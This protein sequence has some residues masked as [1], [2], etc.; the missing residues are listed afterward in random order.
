MQL[1]FLPQPTHESPPMF[2]SRFID[3]F[4]RTHW[5][6]VPII[7]GP[8]VLA[9]LWFAV[10]QSG[11]SWLAALGVA[12][13]GALAWSL[14]EYWLHRTVFHWQ[15]PGELGERFH[16]ILHGVHHKWPRDRF[17]LV[18]PPAVSISLFWIFLGLWLVLFPR[19]AYAFHAG[20]VAGYMFY[21]L[22]HYYI[23]H[24]HPQQAWL[25]KLRKHHMVHHSPNLENEK[26]FGVSSTLWDH[27]FG[28]YTEAK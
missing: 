13:L 22:S 11:L 25:K 20:F 26:K 4:S 9:L 18:M 24:G 28:T 14:T 5:S 19:I 23:H 16:F 1:L 27:V 10:A 6:A 3:Q 7:F 8:A 15:P 17:R 12:A 2:G 21:D